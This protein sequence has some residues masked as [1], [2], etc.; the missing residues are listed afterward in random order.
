MTLSSNAACH[1]WQ[2]LFKDTFSRY[3]YSGIKVLLWGCRWSHSLEA[4]LV[5]RRAWDFWCHVRS[6]SE[7]SACF[8]AWTISVSCCAQNDE[9]LVCIG[10]KHYTMEISTENKTREKTKRKGSRNS[11][12]DEDHCAAILN[13]LKRSRCNE[14]ITINEESS[15]SSNQDASILI[16]GV[17]TQVQHNMCWPSITISQRQWWDSFATTYYWRL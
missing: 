6:C 12:G 4:V 13:L 3:Q 15:A 9:S 16:A 11:Q 5:V 10:V 8:F 17:A 14:E 1:Q 7:L 2:F